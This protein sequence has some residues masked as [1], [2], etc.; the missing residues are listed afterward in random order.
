[1]PIVITFFS[2]APLPSSSSSLLHVAPASLVP[3]LVHL[4]MTRSLRRRPI[5]IAL[6]KN[7]VG[8]KN[9]TT[10]LPRSPPPQ[11]STPGRFLLHLVRRFLRHSTATPHVNLSTSMVTFLSSAVF[12]S[13]LSILHRFHADFC[14]ILEQCH[15]TLSPSLD[16]DIRFQRHGLHLVL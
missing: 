9:D 11:N 5:H 8:S 3:S 2:S 7:A 16:F 15:Y 6:D 12:S 1:M 10:F 14:N 13:I 4:T